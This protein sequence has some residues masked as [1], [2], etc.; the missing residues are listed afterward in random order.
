MTV[1][2]AYTAIRAWLDVKSR[3]GRF[4]LRIDDTDPER[5]IVAP[6]EIMSDLHSIGLTW[7]EGPDVGGPCEPYVVS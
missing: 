2:N 1:A 6:D 7:D 3:D 4:V 5:N